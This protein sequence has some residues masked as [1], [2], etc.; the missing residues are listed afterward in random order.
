MVAMKPISEGLH[1]DHRQML[2]VCSW[3]ESLQGWLRST[4]AEYL[5]AG[6]GLVQAHLPRFPSRLHTEYTFSLTMKSFSP[7]QPSIISHSPHYI[8]E[9]DVF[10]L[11]LHLRT[12][13]GEQM[14][15]VGVEKLPKNMEKESRNEL[16][17]WNNLYMSLPSRIL[18]YQETGCPWCKTTLRNHIFLW[19]TSTLR[20]ASG[21]FMAFCKGGYVSGPVF[22]PHYQRGTLPTLASAMKDANLPQGVVEQIIHKKC[23]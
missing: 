11:V 21:V 12:L 18:D 14:A 6:H 13:P 8:N 22:G 5:A 4:G 15:W 3:Q 2:T 19:R 23:V 20:A 16:K 10:H 9:V 17:H 7:P 1:S